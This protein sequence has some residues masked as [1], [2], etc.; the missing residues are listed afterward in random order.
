VLRI[1][2]RFARLDPAGFYRW[3]SALRLVN[4]T[5]RLLP[6][7]APPLD[8]FP[9]LRGFLG[10]PLRSGERYRDQRPSPWIFRGQS[11]FLRV[12]AAGDPSPALRAGC[13]NRAAGL[14]AVESFGF[15]GCGRYAAFWFCR[16]KIGGE[17]FGV[18]SW[19]SGAV[20]AEKR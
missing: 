1:E 17:V 11:L 18:G 10:N 16:V 8:P 5:P 3:L 7:E 13:A 9:A 14:Q 19:G 12:G 15:V 2:P 6:T 4:Q 20:G